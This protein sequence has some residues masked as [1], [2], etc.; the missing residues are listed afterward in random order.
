MALRAVENTSLPDKVFEQL[1]VEIVS[2]RYAPGATIPSERALSAVLTVNRHVVREAVKRLEQVGLVKVVQGG[3]TRVLDFRRTA[4]LDLL[5][6]IAEH[7]DAIEGLVPLLPAALEMRLGIGADVARL[8]ALNA[9][10]G[11]GE[12]LVEVSERLAEVARGVELLPLDQ[13]FWQHMLDGAGNLAY[14]L[15]FNS[16]IRGVHAI[17]EL[18]APWLEHELEVSDYRRPIA[19]AILAGD[20]ALAVEVTRTALLPAV[21]AFAAPVKRPRQGTRLA[22]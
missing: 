17:P 11:V 19:A 16:L 4:G 6:V 14:Q 21:E 9:G 18:T 7:A 10:S 15:A 20:A 5:A 12:D 8:C 22:K 1:L 13:L 3:G 2:G